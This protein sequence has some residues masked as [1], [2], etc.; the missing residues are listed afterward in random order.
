[1]KEKYYR[2]VNKPATKRNFADFAIDPIERDALKAAAETDLAK[3]F[4]G[5]EGRLAHKW[6]HYLDIYDRHFSKYRGTS[7]KMLEIGVS[8]GGSLDMWRQYFGP[9]AII[10]GIDIEQSCAERVTPPNQV[11]IGSQDDAEFLKRVLAEIGTPDIILDDGSHIG[12][13]Q[14]ASFKFLF[15]HLAEGG[16]Y[17][18]EDLHTSYWPGV[19]EG[20]YRRRGTGIEF[21]KGLVDDLH[22]HYHG[23]QVNETY[24]DTIDSI[25]FYDS[26]AIIDK[27]QRGR[28]GHIRLG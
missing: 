4:Y 23:E 9:D 7:V 20:G 18:I 25:R 17:A 11:R 22:G 13:H 3:Q 24:R 1:M 2:L 28:L 21:L 19:L 26:I 12:R 27:V 8:Q 6:L 5:H 15:P 16:I 14:E 10:F